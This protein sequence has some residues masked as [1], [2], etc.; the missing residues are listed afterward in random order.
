MARSFIVYQGEDETPEFD[1]TDPTSNVH[2]KFEEMEAGGRAFRGESASNTIP[3]RDQSGETGNELNLPGGLT[4]VSLSRGSRWEWLDGPDGSEVRMAAGRIGTKDYTRGV[5]KASRA[6]EV[7]MQAGD[8]NE[9]LQDII[10]DAWDRAEETDVVRVNA[11]IT[12]YLSGTPRATTN[13]A[14]TYVSSDGPVTLP[15]RLYDGTNPRNILQEIAQF[16]NKE[17]FVTIDDELWY[18]VATSESYLAGLRISDR[19]EEWTTEGSS[20]GAS[21]VRLY[22]TGITSGSGAGESAA[23]PALGGLTDADASWGGILSFP[24]KYMYDSP[25]AVASGAV[26]DESWAVVDSAAGS[27]VIDGFVHYLDGDL[28]SVVQG[29]G[30][31]RGQHRMKSRHGIGVNEDAQQNFSNFAVRVY[32]PGTGIVATLVDVGDSIG[33]VRFEPSTNGINNSFGPATMTAYP[34]A[35]EGDYLVVDVGTQHVGPTTGATGAGVFITDTEGTDYGIDSTDQLLKNTWWQF[36]PAEESLPVWGPRW[37]VGPASTEDG[38]ELVSGLRLY[39]GQQGDYVHVT[40]PTTEA[41]YWH[42]ERSFY[43]SDEAITDATK[44]TV[45][46]EAILQRLKF[47]DRTYNV[48]VGPMY[49]EHVHLLKPGQLVDIKARAIPDADDQYVSRRIAQLKWTTPRPG[50]FWARMQL[51]RPLKEAPYGVGPKQSAEEIAKHTQ[52]SSSHT[53]SQVTIVDSGGFYTATDVEAALQ[54]LAGSVTSPDVIDHGSMGATETFDF[55]DGSDH[56]GVQNA[57][58]TVTLTGAT[59][60]QA[61]FMTLVLTQDGT[62]GHSINLPSS[63]V[64]DTTIEA[65]WDQAASAV[66]ILT[67]F[68]YDGGTNWYAFLAGGSGAGATALDD[69]TDVTITAPATDEDLR[70]VAGE[71]VNDPRKWEAVTNGEDVFVWE[72]DDLVHEWNEAP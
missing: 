60:G 71:W 19:P 55:G 16:A 12:T 11:L 45:L 57:D 1:L 31:A 6:R 5:Q 61:A 34:S 68:T 7:V 59:A 69:L 52:A 38:L 24:Y 51:D 70:Y 41:E 30:V 40:D 72:S 36:G 4:H 32:R 43:T 13:I 2:V 9:E 27:V 66:N 20:P 15:A 48:S 49:L 3:I 23:A 50:V 62:G 39:Y 42:A 35:V 8:R 33:I 29:G 44:A 67:L 65:A 54:E 26:P 56:E 28:L 14:N 22:P 64:N 53:A 37:D 25:Q 46:A 17:F 63:V 58:L 47:E 18:D 21:T 10:V